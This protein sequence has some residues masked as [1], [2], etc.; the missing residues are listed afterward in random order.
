MNVV[1][2]SENTLKDFFEFCRTHR[3]VH[4]ESFLYEEDL[5]AFEI[6]DNNPTYLLYDKNKL[7]GVLSILIT[8]YLLNTNRSRVRIFYCVSGLKAHY[9]LLM[10]ALEPMRGEVKKI[11]M[12]VPDTKKNTVKI[13][14]DMGYTYYQTSYV[15]E[16]P[17]PEK[18]VLD[19]PDGY[20]LKPIDKEK[21]V[22][23]YMTIRNEAFKSVRGSE[24]PI[25]EK[26]AIERF[27]ED[28]VLTDGI[29]LLWHGEKAIGL[30]H[31]IEEIDESGKHSF[32]APIA[33]LPEYHGKG[34]GTLL[35]KAG[36]NITVDNGYDNCMLC[37]IAEN[38]K[39]LALYTKVGFKT[40]M[41]ISA[42]MK[43]V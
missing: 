27:N 4:D 9:E 13:V 33:V 39:A 34:F 16:R 7:I 17:T 38:E 28:Y 41:S 11:Q 2:L 24:A 40:T 36:L 26:I 32:V 14:K 29:Q 5:E 23:A 6:G 30:V 37:V 25:S 21:D 31:M 22:K 1:K 18:V 12:Y 8:E 35:L 15:M 43:E 3:Y 42:Y 20:T 19:V 10:N